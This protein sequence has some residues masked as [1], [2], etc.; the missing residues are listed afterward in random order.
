MKGKAKEEK[1]ADREQ[2]TDDVYEVSLTE[3]CPRVYFGK[4]LTA[5]AVILAVAALLFYC[6]FG[7]KN[8]LLILAVP[9]QAAGAILRWLSLSSSV[10][11]LAAL[12][13]FAILG[14]WPFV[15]F[16]K[17]KSGLTPDGRSCVFLILTSL[18]LWMNLYFG[19]NPAALAK[20]MPMAAGDA[21][22]IKIAQVIIGG[23]FY[24]TVIAWILS[25]QLHALETQQEAAAVE[26][27]DSVFERKRLVR[28]VR[29]LLEAA[30]VLEVG[31]VAYGGTY[32]V[33]RSV[34]GAWKGGADIPGVLLKQIFLIIPEIYM[35]LLLLA[36]I[37]LLS[38]LEKDTFSQAVQ[39]AFERLGDISSRTAKASIYCGV[40]YN[41][42]A[43][44]FA[45]ASADTNL[46]L[47]IPV[48]PLLLAFASL[49]L[50]QYF[51][52]GKVLQEENDSFI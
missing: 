38:E 48:L 33:C 37:A 52:A 19:V 25:V 49:L 3:V 26:D 1:E 17:A 4:A 41:L 28:K 44:G 18:M 15:F 22:I 45:A 35:V 7:M 24:S 13:L 50:V 12:A 36:G 30:S 23:G 34:L 46:R 40:L 5:E 9:F 20:I 11:N 47:E 21:E 2:G 39:E 14:G 29:L 10:G 32:Q 43:L 8:A 6:V 42:T 51:K 31:Q 16:V 27:K